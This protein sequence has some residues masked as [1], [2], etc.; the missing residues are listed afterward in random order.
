MFETRFAQRVTAYAAG[1]EQ[2]QRD[3]GAYGARLRKHFDPERP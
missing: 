2:V 3:Y 1:V